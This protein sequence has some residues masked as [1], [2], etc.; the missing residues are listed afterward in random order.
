V[1][2]PLRT[3]IDIQPGAESAAA[4]RARAQKRAW[5]A[6]RDY[7]VVEVQAAEI[8]ADVQAALD[9]LAQRLSRQS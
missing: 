7:L 1:S 4:A 5:L 2:F 6:E 9:R 8:E 3:V